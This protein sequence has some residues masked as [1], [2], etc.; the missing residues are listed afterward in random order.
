M[1]ATAESIEEDVM[2]ERICIEEFAK[3]IA[4]VAAQYPNA[5]VVS[6]GSGSDGF[7]WHYSIWLKHHGNEI[8]ITIPVYA[9]DCK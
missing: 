4:D 8:R 7:S 1:K 3:R 2:E 5:Q 6:V 9:E